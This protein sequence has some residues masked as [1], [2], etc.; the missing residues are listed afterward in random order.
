[1]FSRI[2]IAPRLSIAVAV[3]LVILALL[4]GNNVYMKWETRA[5]MMR[6]VELAEGVKT[7]SDLIHEMQRERGMS[8]TFLTS[9]GE[10]MKS[11]LSAQRKRTD[12]Q[13]AHLSSVMDDLSA[14][15]EIDAKRRQVSSLSLTNAQSFAYYSDTIAK[16]LDIATDMAK[17]SAHGDVTRTM[18]AYVT[19]M[20]GKELAGQERAT[21]SAAIAVG[22]FEFPSY[23]RMLSLAAAQAADFD[24]FKAIASAD[25][26]D[27]FEQTMSG[28][29]ADTVLRMR[30]TIVSGGLAGELAGLDARSWF[31]ATAA[32][33]DLL[34]S[35]EDRI[36]EALVEKTGAISGE[37]LQALV[38][39]TS[40]TGLVL[41]GSLLLV[42]MI[43]R[44]I[45]RPL[46]SLGGAMKRLAT[47]ELDTAVPGTDRSDEIGEMANAVGI[48]K[49]HAIERRRL[50]AEQR[51]SELRATKVRRNEML[52]LAGE[53]ETAVGQIV[54]SVSSAAGE[55]ETAAGSLTKTAEMTR[56]LS[57][58]VA[59]ASEQASVN[60]QSVASA[61]NEMS[62]SV[63]EI[64]RQVVESS[65]IADE[66][67][68]QAQKTD[69]RITELSR[70]AQ[71]I[72]DVVDLISAIAGQTNLLALNATIEAARAGDAGKGFAI[73]AEEVK[74][75]AAQTAKATEE[76]GSQISGMQAATEESVSAI[77]E[78]SGTISRIATISSTIA[79]AVEE[80]GTATHMIA[81]NIDEAAK[82]TSEVASNITEVDRGAAE[83]G[84]ASSQVLSSAQTLSQQSGR[85]KL[86]VGS[87]LTTIRA[88]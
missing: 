71:R 82:G 76:I 78:I 66:A 19:L 62:S 64:S 31:E 46:D 33:I 21:G 58:T 83:T 67:V 73:V 36:G 24:R 57:T 61:T 18:V 56:H 59:A 53:F 55:L 23:T 43:A 29:A 39:L 8:A 45:T 35:I 37:A 7:V 5:E 10:Q 80:Q 75:L 72:G 85:L 11:D 88:A 16:L 3:P 70:A 15:Q 84:S 2:R 38:V 34:K 81:R 6:L 86:Q 27:L 87:F 68:Q 12:E 4:A 42:L 74:A 17:K 22:R 9:N 25:M 41:A 47:G 28:Q 52:K 30:E 79:A 69:A 63:N 14:I 44:S 54:E 48:F 49:S 77:K 40:T 32:R 60:V 13:R 1:M 20:Q 50:E 65:R 26:R 51:E